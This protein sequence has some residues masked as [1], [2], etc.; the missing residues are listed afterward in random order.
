MAE[1]GIRKPSRTIVSGRLFGHRD[2]HCFVVADAP[3]PETD[4]NIY[5]AHE[6][7]G[8]A[9]HGERVEVRVERARC[10]GRLE[11]RIHRVLDRA[12]K[13]VVAEFGSGER[14]NYV[15]WFYKRVLHEV[16]IAQS[17]EWP[18]MPQAAVQRRVGRQPGSGGVRNGRASIGGGL[19][20][21][22]RPVIRL[23][24]LAD[25]LRSGFL[26]EISLQ[27]A[28]AGLHEAPEP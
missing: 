13:T 4:H 25:H 10:G 18:A 12:Q 28:R 6:G 16:V 3:L 1:S 7:M 23:G 24:Q 19:Y 14:S 26:F 21:R 17:P 2:G 9:M 5:I 8:S 22:L 11:G 15:L 20:S 27:L